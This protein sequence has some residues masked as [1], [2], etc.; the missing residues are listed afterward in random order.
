MKVIIATFI[1]IVFIA[2]RSSS[3]EDR[4][5]KEVF[6]IMEQA[7]EYIRTMKVN[8]LYDMTYPGAFGKFSKEEVL[9][10]LAEGMHNGEYDLYVNKIYIDSVYDV[11]KVNSDK[12]SKVTHRLD[13][14]FKINKKTAEDSMQMMERFDNYCQNFGKTSGNNASCDYK[15]GKI[16]LVI[17]DYS[18][19]IFLNKE[20]KW[21][22]L[23]SQSVLRH[24]NLIPKEVMDKL[25]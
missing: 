20:K 25:N 6:K 18:L 24:P 4:D 7:N 8:A 3:Q 9:S 14:I 10:D 1:L 2:C 19:V 13:A 12:Y 22:I 5:K 17:K 16:N 21:Y 11:F 15:T 23:S